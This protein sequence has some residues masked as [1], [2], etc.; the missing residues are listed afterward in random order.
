MNSTGLSPRAL[1]LSVALASAFGCESVGPYES[2]GPQGTE[3]SLEELRLAMEPYR[4]VERA[5]SDGYVPDFRMTCE[6]PAHMGR[7]AE[8]GTMG[9]HYFR[10][11]L[12]GITEDETRVD[13]RGTHTDFMEP[14]VLV[15][16]PQEDESLELVAIANLVSRGAWEAE[17]NVVP[18]TFHGTPFH[19]TEANPASY[20]EA[21]YDRH[22][23]LFRDNPRGVFAQYN[24]NVT[25]E[26]QD[27]ETW[28]MELMGMDH[29]EE[30]GDSGTYRTEPQ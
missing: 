11:D 15:Y 13:V 29:P 26:H 10:P 20:V 30:V 23:W 22:I 24:P 4:D 21:H 1:V 16:E 6:T 18:P 12:L 8:L 25:C 2:Q 14:A 27:L 17:G 7:P 28:M 9:I 3:P 5:L 19:L